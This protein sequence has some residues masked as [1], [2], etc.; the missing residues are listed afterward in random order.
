VRHILE[1]IQAS[2]LF[3]VNFSPF[4]GPEMAADRAKGLAYLRLTQKVILELASEGDAVII[5]RGSQF[6]LHNAPRTLHIYIFAPL[7]YRIERIMQ[8]FRL[9][10]THALELIEQR[11][12]EYD[13]YARRFYGM[14][15]HQPELYHLLI[16]TSLFSPELSANLIEQT[17]PL[18]KEI[19]G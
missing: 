11:D 7:T 2:H 5:G 17:L 15:R 16:N 13:D 1:A 10:R 18:A 12:Y 14:N 4:F 19:G 9:D 6:V 8:G 3:T